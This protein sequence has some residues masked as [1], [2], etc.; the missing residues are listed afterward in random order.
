MVYGTHGRYGFLENSYRFGKYI[1]NTHYYVKGIRGFVMII[2]TPDDTPFR[3]D[4]EVFMYGTLDTI[5]NQPDTTY[6]LHSDKFGSEDVLFWSPIVQKRLVIVTQKAPSLNKAAKELCVVDDKL[7]TKKNDDIFLVVKA[8]LN[9]TDR[10]RIK[11]VFGDPPIALLLWFLR[12]NETDIDVWRRFAK[13]QYIL[14]E[15]YLKA[16]IIYGIQPSRKRVVWPKKKGKNKERPAMFQSSDKHWELLLENSI[17]VAN[18]V[19]DSDEVPK[20]MRRRKV[21]QNSWV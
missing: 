10:E 2:F 11:S 17:S 7:K 13:V 18:S 4:S 1:P 3:S 21:A 15:K 16:A 12:G 6:F 20:G 14:P 9:W 5:P 19:R 8:L